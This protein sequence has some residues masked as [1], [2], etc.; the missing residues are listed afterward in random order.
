MLV[1]NS[2]IKI[3][4]RSSQKLKN[5]DFHQPYKRN[6]KIEISI[7]R[8]LKLEKSRFPLSRV[9]NLKTQFLL[10]RVKIKLLSLLKR[11][12]TIDQKLSHRIKWRSAKWRSAKW[13]SAKWR[14][15]KWRSAKLVIL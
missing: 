3:S 11:S 13:R 9:R 2:K 1:E 14:S 5:L 10:E 15:A 6:S 12:K 7:H 4:I 8:S